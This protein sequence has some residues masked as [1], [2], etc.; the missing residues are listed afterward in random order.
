M[1]LAVQQAHNADLP[2]GVLPPGDA[3]VLAVRDVDEGYRVPGRAPGVARDTC[4]LVRFR[5]F[6]QYF[7]VFLV[8]LP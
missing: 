6:L 4:V 8:R 5:L 2:R 3:V 7:S 1:G